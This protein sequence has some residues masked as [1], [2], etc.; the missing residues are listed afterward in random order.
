MEII[1]KFKIYNR[2]YLFLIYNI[3]GA[4][5]FQAIEELKL[6][7][8]ILSLGKQ[9]FRRLFYLQFSG[10]FILHSFTNISRKAAT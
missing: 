5:L 10:K 3:K 1:F 8:Y 9:T 4:A 6:D 2:Y 7:M